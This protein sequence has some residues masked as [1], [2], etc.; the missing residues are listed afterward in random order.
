MSAQ[1]SSQDP[2]QDSSQDPAQNSSQN[3]AQNSS[4]DPA[5]DPAQH[6]AQNSSQ[7][8]LETLLSARYS[9][10]LPLRLNIKLHQEAEPT[11]I[12]LLKVLRILPGK[13]VV[14]LAQ[15][16]GK[17]VVAK[18]FYDQ[19]RWQQHL[20]RELKG[21]SAM[22]EA[23]IQFAP[24]LGQGSLLESSATDKKGAVL[25]M[26]YLEHGDSLGER[27]QSYADRKFDQQFLLR[28]VI[29][30]IAWCHHRGLIQQDIHLDNF[31]LQGDTIYLL[32]AA[33]IEA[34]SQSDKL[35]LNGCLD[36]LALFFAQFPVSNDEQLP[37]HYQHYL[38]CR[39]LLSNNSIKGAPDNSAFLSLLH[40]RR[41]RR[42]HLY[43]RK[44][45]RETSANCCEKRFD[46]FV[47]YE[48]SIA[49]AELEKF[50][51]NPDDFI[52]AGRV[53]KAGNSATVAAI[54]IG[55][56]E[57]IVKRYNI[58]NLWHGLSRALRPSRAWESW[59]NA[60]ML[61]MFGLGTAKPWLMME[62]RSGPLRRQAYFVAE[63]LPGQDVLHFLEKEPIKCTPWQTALQQFR[64]LFQIMQ[65][66]QIVHGDMKATNFISTPEQLLILDL[67]AMRQESS[68]A[69]FIKAFNKDLQR[70]LGNWQGNE[71]AEQAVRQLITDFTMTTPRAMLRKKPQA[72]EEA[73]R[74][75][76]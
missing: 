33:A 28:R 60:H 39:K 16:Q 69:K 58:K 64:Q 1:N 44:L 25:L 49:S 19:Q 63:A 34:F 7:E 54:T 62:R 3:S 72:S 71:P 2:A 51:N 65:Q 52:R 12:E 59:R 76:G 6:P 37:A 68:R 61:Q 73:Q 50:I 67:D 4:Q 46:R 66:Y 38:S 24:V 53:I 32:D 40:Q 75:R 70:F 30:Q 48:R 27:W 13:R 55:G 35:P 41:N 21:I 57:Y 74:T 9:L 43:S 26:H 45:F 15:W 22:Q 56:R 17:T 20:Q 5:Q 14:A 31:L 8:S 42:W 11:Q 36:N 10:P 18:L 29:S 47:V 23:A